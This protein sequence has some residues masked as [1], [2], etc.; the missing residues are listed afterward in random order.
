MFKHVA[1]RGNIWVVK[2]FVNH[3]TCSDGIPLNVSLVSRW[4]VMAFC[5]RLSTSRLSSPPNT[6]V[7]S[8]ASEL[9]C[10]PNSVS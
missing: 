2:V 7:G 4:L 9:F 8:M 10:S 5:E 6:P 3:C 1:T